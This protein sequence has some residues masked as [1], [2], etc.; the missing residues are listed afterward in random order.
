MLVRSA[1]TAAQNFAGRT[2]AWA[3]RQALLQL[4]FPEIFEFAGWDQFVSEGKPV[5]PRYKAALRSV[6]ELASIAQWKSSFVQSSVSAPFLLVQQFPCSAGGRLLD[7]SHMG[8]LGFADAWES[9]RLGIGAG[10]K[11]SV[12]IGK[13][14]VCSLCN[15]PRCGLAHL[16]ASCSGTCDIREAFL[17]AS[18]HGFS[19]ALQGAP[20]G[21][22]PSVL[23]SPH[24]D[25]D[26]LMRAVE[27]CARVM[28]AFESIRRD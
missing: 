8:H 7:A 28:K 20:A 16:L 12:S 23:L 2:F 9:L 11:L 6:H 27:Y 21:D 13:V 4:E 1:W 3:S 25:L 10:S 14:K 22:W 24:S 18:D 19:T 17:S 5:L 26:K 15:G